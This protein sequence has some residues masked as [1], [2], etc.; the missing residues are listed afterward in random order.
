MLTLSGSDFNNMLRVPSWRYSC[1]YGSDTLSDLKSTP[2]YCELP[3]HPGSQLRYPQPS[4]NFATGPVQ[5]L[6]H[7]YQLSPP[8]LKP[9]R[10]S[11]SAVGILMTLTCA[12]DK[13]HSASSPARPDSPHTQAPSRK[14]P[15]PLPQHLP[16]STPRPKP[17]HQ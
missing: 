2:L 5:Y 6:R 17:S 4:C 1:F 10:F 3:C 15:I 8:S 12:A 9:S 13:S 14:R 16:S 7:W 11:R